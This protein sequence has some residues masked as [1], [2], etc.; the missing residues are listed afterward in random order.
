MLLAS[1]AAQGWAWVP[2]W[3]ASG[4]RA[5]RRLMADWAYPV[6]CTVYP[7]GVPGA[8]VRAVLEIENRKNVF[9]IPRQALFEKEGKKLVYRKRGNRFEPVPVEI[10]SSTPG[11]VVVTKGISRDDELALRDPTVIERSEK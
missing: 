7:H 10:A 1:P 6:A 5:H 8:R 2:H 11:R 3:A 4:V 9:S